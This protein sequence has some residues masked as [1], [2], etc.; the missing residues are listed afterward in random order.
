MDFRTE[1]LALGREVSSGDMPDDWESG[2]NFGRLFFEAA[3]Q[4]YAW[5]E[6]VA[7][8]LSFKVKAR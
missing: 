2:L 5:D 6:L 7:I 8:C 3:L 4:G 1:L